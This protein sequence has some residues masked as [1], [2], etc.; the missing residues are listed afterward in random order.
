MKPVSE[1]TPGQLNKRLESLQKKS[2]RI[3]EKFIRAGRG[4]ERPTEI[5]QQSDKLSQEYKYNQTLM[6]NVFD[7]ITKRYGPNVRR[8]PTRSKNPMKKGSHNKLLLRDNLKPAAALFR[9]SVEASKKH[10]NKVADAF[11]KHGDHGPQISGVIRDHFPTDVKD[12]L[13]K[14]ARDVSKFS[15]AAYAARPKG[16]RQNTMWKLSQ[17]V[18]DKYGHAFY[19]PQP[20]RRKNPVKGEPNYHN[21]MFLSL[22]QF[23][24]TMSNASKIQL[25]DAIKSAKLYV[26]DFSMKAEHRAKVKKL[27]PLMRAELKGFAKGRQINPRKVTRK[28]RATYK[29]TY[30]FDDYNDAKKYAIA[31][32]FPTNRII[33]YERGWAIQLKVSGGYVGPDTGKTGAVC[34]RCKKKTFVK[35]S[36]GG[37]ACYECDF[38]QLRS[39]P[40]IEIRELIL[41]SENLPAMHNQYVSIMKNLSRKKKRGVYD[42]VLAAKL[43]KYWI[44]E[45]VKQY[46]KEVLGGGYSLKQSVFTMQDRKQAAI[47]MEDQEQEGVFSMEYLELK[48]PRKKNPRKNQ[49]WQVFKCKGNNLMFY[50]IPTPGSKAVHWSKDKRYGMAFTYKH[51]A[52]RTAQQLANKMGTTYAIGIT[53]Y[54]ST[55][56]EIKDA[57]SGKV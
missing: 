26:A 32:K 40:E 24:R 29:G 30:Y 43:W 44:D 16:V 51:L 11:N 28:K 4:S 10:S 23:V 35:Q 55:V 37:A 46:N 50:M 3:T 34:P 19:G 2:S 18:A 12:D 54:D 36:T 53:D 27:I 8:A 39:N 38:G 21:Q 42:P 31:N 47:E 9:K 49:L 13:R 52:E 56:K 22:L 41:F 57:C 1:L 7:E 33:D 14:L 6:N 20:T 15:D 5:W 48:N 45:G 25:T 17:A